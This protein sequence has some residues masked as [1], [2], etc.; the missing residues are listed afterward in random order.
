MYFVLYNNLDRGIGPPNFENVVA[1][2]FSAGAGVININRYT[3]ATGRSVS[4]GQSQK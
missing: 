2:L 1:P 4:S 3:G